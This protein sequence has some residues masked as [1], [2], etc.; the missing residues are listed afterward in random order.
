MIGFTIGKS[1][2]YYRVTVKEET[3]S[4]AETKSRFKSVLIYVQ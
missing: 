4:P 2:I 1:T 3:S